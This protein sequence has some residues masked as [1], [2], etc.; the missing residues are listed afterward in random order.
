MTKTEKSLLKEMGE[1]G[2]NF[3]KKEFSKTK[4]INKLN[5]TFIEISDKYSKNKIT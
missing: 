5:K 2:I 4:L 1:N 3:A